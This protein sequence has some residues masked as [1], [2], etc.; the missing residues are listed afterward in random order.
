VLEPNGAGAVSVCNV[1]GVIAARHHGVVDIQRF[2]AGR[3][4]RTQAPSP[5]EP[6]CRIIAIAFARSTSRWC[7]EI[8]IFTPVSHGLTLL[9]IGAAVTKPNSMT[10]QLDPSKRKCGTSKKVRQPKRAIS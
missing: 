7:S 3:Q 4:W 8:Q 1:I 9:A 2:A 6:D 10:G 5:I